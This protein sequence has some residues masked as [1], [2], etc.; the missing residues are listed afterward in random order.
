MPYK[1][2]ISEM[3]RFQVQ[4]KFIMY[5]EDLYHMIIIITYKKNQLRIKN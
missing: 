4:K 5:S 2:L 3:I 1:K